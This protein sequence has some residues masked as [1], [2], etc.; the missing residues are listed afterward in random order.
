MTMSCVAFVPW[1]PIL[2]PGNALPHALV[3]SLWSLTW[4]PRYWGL[5]PDG[6]LRRNALLTAEDVGRLQRWV[7]H[8]QSTVSLLLDGADEAEAFAQP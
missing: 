1:S 2:R 8:I 4:Y 7:D 5:D 3:N 6:M